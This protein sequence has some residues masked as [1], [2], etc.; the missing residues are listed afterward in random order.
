MT[1]E[2]KLAL[3]AA[4]NSLH[5]AIESWV[6]AVSTAK[7]A[8]GPEDPPIPVAPVHLE[9]CGTLSAHLEAI[10]GQISSIKTTG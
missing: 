3:M 5:A 2:Q 9:K 6:A 8:T 7:A 4:A 10:F 1:R